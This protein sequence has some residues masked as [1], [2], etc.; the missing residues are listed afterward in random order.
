MFR[1]TVMF[2]FKAG[3]SL[4]QINAISAALAQLPLIITEIRNYS[5]GRDAGVNE[6]NFDFAVTGTFDSV[7]QYLVYRDHPEHQRFVKELVAPVLESR[8]A[9]QFSDER[10]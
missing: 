8:A 7:D 10:N 1:H 5:F 3:T 4:E 2:R 6:G 9:V